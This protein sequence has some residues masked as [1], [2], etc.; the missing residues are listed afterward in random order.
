VGVSG[1][2]A[3]FAPFWRVGVEGSKVLVLEEGVQGVGGQLVG[4]D[5]SRRDG[6]C[7][8][9]REFLDSLLDLDWDNGVT[10]NGTANS[11]DATDFFVG[12]FGG[13]R[14]S[15]ESGTGSEDALGEAEARTRVSGDTFV[16]R[17]SC[18]RSARGTVGQ[19][20]TSE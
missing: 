18:G 9:I 10:G 5:R 1:R 20:L 2:V 8:K 12:D 6:V 4:S 13:D 19:G 16:V 3:A 7:G 17:Q 14:L 15:N 11:R